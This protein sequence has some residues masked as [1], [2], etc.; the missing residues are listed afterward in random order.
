MKKPKIPVINRFMQIQI[1]LL[2]LIAGGLILGTTVSGWFYLLAAVGIFGPVILKAFG[3]MP[4]TDE[5]QKR[6]TDIAARNGYL[7]AGI[8]FILIM[9][10][11]QLDILKITDQK[12]LWIFGFTLTISTYYIS[13]ALCFWNTVKAGQRILFAFGFFW[14]TFVI[15]SEWGN[16]TAFLIELLVV[17]LPFILLI[18]LSR[19]YPRTAG[20]ILIGIAVFGI[21]F[22]DFYKLFLGNF[23]YI[24]AFM[25]L[26]LPLIIAGIC[27]IK[28]GG[29][30]KNPPFAGKPADE[31][32]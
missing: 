1:I 20:L 11:I 10:L 22:F 18:F 21:F 12:S 25:I 29:K 27:F 17:P 6:I 14:L 7:A 2:I 3:L 30:R 28:A 13:Y 24:F 23:Q 15:L 5:F 19:K 8:Y 9:M 31:Q 4:E 26:P 16:W 32:N